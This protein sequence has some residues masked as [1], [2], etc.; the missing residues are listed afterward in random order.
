MCRTV[1]GVLVLL[2]AL[3]A[4]WADDKPKDKPTTPQ[5]QYQALLKEHQDAMQAF[6]KEVMKAKTDEERVKVIQD[7]YPKPDNLAAKL[8]ELAEKNAKDPVAFEALSWILT[9]DRNTG[10]KGGPADKAVALLLRDYLQSDKLAG[11]CQNL[12]YRFTQASVN[13]YRGILD[14]SPGGEVQAEACLAL[15][16]QLATTAQIVRL[17]KEEPEKAKGYERILGGKEQ[18]EEMR[19]ADLAKTEA[20]SARYFKEFGEKYAPKMKPARLTEVCRL[21][22]VLGGAGGKT[23][24]R[25]LMEKDARREVQCAACLAMAQSLK[26]RADRLPAAQA[27]DAEKVRK[28]SEELF[29]RAADKYA[30]VKLDASGPSVGDQATGAL[31]AMRFLSVGKEAPEVEG[32]DA[33]GKKFKLSDYRGKVV[34]LDFW[35]HW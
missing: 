26:E 2:L 28:E 1:G 17:L 16:Q 22:P 20:E 33:D 25:S 27:A 8:L 32:E 23:L 3:P 4:A 11:L 7:K 12:S 14:K 30:D 34:L 6:E 15:A 10:G 5:E 21:L 24:L 35:G 18:A 19:K 9:N 13:L 31:F 29:E